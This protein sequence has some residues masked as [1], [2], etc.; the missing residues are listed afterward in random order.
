V[1]GIG[2]DQ[3]CPNTAKCYQSKVEINYLLRVMVNEKSAPPGVVTV[4]RKN[5]VSKYWKATT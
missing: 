1:S 5:K 3:Q 2:Q 4:C